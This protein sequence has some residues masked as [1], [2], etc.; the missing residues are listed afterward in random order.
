MSTRKNK[1]Q[2]ETLVDIVE[3]RD[4]AQ[5]FFERNQMLIIGALAVV[6][7]LIGGIFAYNVLYKKPKNE[8]ALDQMFQAQYQFDRDSFALALDN[9]GGGYDGFLD[10]IDNYKGTQAANLAH[11]YAGVCYLHLGRYDAAIDYLETFKPGGNITPV[12]KHGLLGDA[13]SEIGEFDKAKS[14]YERAAKEGNAYLAPYYLYK[15]AMLHER[16]GDYARSLEIYEEIKQKY[17][18]STV[19][20]D[21]DKYIARA[22]A[23]SE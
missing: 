10:I 19:G 17:S 16:E 14:L 18:D 3:V 9:P 15:L 5:D 12:M 2:E 21:I 1:K 6:A 20:Q 11:Y 13:N 23:A 4:Q 8:E 22:R 7:I